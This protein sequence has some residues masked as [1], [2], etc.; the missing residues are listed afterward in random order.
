LKFNNLSIFRKKMK[1]VIISC[2]CVLFLQASVSAQ[3]NPF[4]I[5]LKF[6][7]PNIAGLNLEY[8]TPLLDNKLAAALDYSSISIKA[9]GNEFSFSYIELGGNYYFMNEGKGLYGNLSFGRVGFKGTYED[10][11][12]GNGKAELA[13]NLINLKLGG[14]FG[15][16][17][18]FRPEV[19]YGILT[20]GSE[21][22][23]EYTDPLTN[24]TVKEK[25]ELP[26]FLA[27][28]AVIN[29]GFGISF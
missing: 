2:L 23:V 17:F 27:G 22:E 9:E 24:E 8:V 14:K 25:E 10:A 16:A 7:V 11:I 13:F 4:R 19:G 12:L 20:G 15:N 29:I 21:I 3:E 18:Y 6:G 5:G 28:G 26:G 1:K